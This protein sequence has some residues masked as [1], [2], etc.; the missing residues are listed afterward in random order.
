MSKICNLS[1]K[2]LRFYDKIG[3]I[4][5]HRHDC[6]NYRYYTSESLLAV[7]VIK[8]YKQMGFTLEEM[9]EFI[10][11]KD[12]NVFKSIKKSFLNKIK[13]FEEEQEKIER[14]HIAVKDWYELILEAETVIENSISDVSVKYIDSAELLCQE[15]YY[16]KDIKA[17][18]VNIDFTNYVEELDNEITGP[19]I[20]YFSPLQDR[21]ENRP[22]AIKI[23]QKTI[24][25]CSKKNRETFGG[26]M[27]ASCY[28]IGSHDTIQQTYQKICKWAGQNGYVLGKGSYERYVT[29]Y[30]TTRNTSK[31]ITEI[32]IKA[33]RMREAIQ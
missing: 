30:W 32:L 1:K 26:C 31:F 6:N 33:T 3:I 17:S 14:K 20:I 22:Q 15:Q 21:I 9:K 24:K 28:H 29:D 4:P 7:P 11:G 13:S 2:A 23:L 25:T 10:E 19:V 16:E 27:M 8:Y 12:P 18:I 5:S